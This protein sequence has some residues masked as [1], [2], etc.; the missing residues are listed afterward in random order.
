[1]SRKNCAI[2][3]LG[4]NLGRKSENLCH[5][6][7][8]I[9]DFCDIVSVSPVYKTQ[10][11]LKDD[12]DSYFNL[13]VAIRTNMEP[14]QLLHTLK[15]IERKL[16]RTNNGRWYTRVLDIDIIDFNR[17]VYKYPKLHIP[18]QQMHKRSFVLYPLMDICPEYVNPESCL[19][20]NSM[21]N[22]IKDDL[23]IKRLGAVV[24]R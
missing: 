12:Q 16:G 13:C 10:S 21:V 9:S 19:S 5:G 2:L 8:L 1:M 23:G 7:K 18:H 15:E 20:I 6:I 4:S 22:I 3:G 11:L 24:W 14:E 17:T